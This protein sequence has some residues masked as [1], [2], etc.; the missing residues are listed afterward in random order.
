MNLYQEKTIYI[1]EIVVTRGD[2]NITGKFYLFWKNIPNTSMYRKFMPSNL[3][4]N[5]KSYFA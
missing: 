5:R 1:T 4:E 3:V 2:K